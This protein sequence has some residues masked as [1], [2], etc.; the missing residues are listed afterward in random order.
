MGLTYFGGYL[1]LREVIPYNN[2][3]SQLETSTPDLS[4]CSS[5]LPKWPKPTPYHS[6]WPVSFQLFLICGLLKISKTTEP[7]TILTF[8]SF[9]ATTINWAK[10]DCGKSHNPDSWDGLQKELLWLLIKSFSDQKRKLLPGT[11]PG[12]CHWLVWPILFTKTPNISTLLPD[13]LND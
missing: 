3:S 6:V 1:L 4:S 13:D 12:T 9:Q 2:S 11:E 5:S 10:P 8:K 7:L